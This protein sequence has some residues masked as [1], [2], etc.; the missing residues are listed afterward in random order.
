MRVLGIDPGLDGGLAAITDDGPM[1]AIMPTQP[2]GRGAGRQIAIDA[3]NDMLLDWSPVEFAVIERQQ[4]MPKQGV[5][6]TFQTGLGYGVLLA[7]LQARRIP[8]EIIQAKTWQRAF[9]IGTG[10][11]KAQAECVARR[12]F[13]DTDLRASERAH[14]AHTG[15]VDALLIAEW[16]RRRQTGA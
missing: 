5:T 2:T 15:I 4:P 9:G 11:T 8:H 14:K 10:D 16:A 7:L 12:L 3:L 6:S 1:V 13:P